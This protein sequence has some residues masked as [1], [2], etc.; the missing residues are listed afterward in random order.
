M[1]TNHV[2]DCCPGDTNTSPAWTRGLKK[3]GHYYEGVVERADLVLEMHKQ[4]T[5]TT[6]GIRRTEKPKS[7]PAVGKENINQEEQQKDSVEK[8]KV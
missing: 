7:A 2:S 5:V 6:F 4:D 1:N 8:P 3:Y